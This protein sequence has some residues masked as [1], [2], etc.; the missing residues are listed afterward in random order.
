M[1]SAF[2]NMHLYCLGGDIPTVCKEV[3]YWLY[4]Y[5]D[6]WNTNYIIFRKKKKKTKQ[7]NQ[8]HT[9]PIFQYIFPYIFQFSLLHF[10][11][12]RRVLNSWTQFICFSVQI[13][14]EPFPLQAQFSIKYMCSN[15]LVDFVQWYVSCCVVSVKTRW[16]RQSNVTH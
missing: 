7:Q 6:L 15:F 13:F 8:T 1:F 2:G 3:C 5:P 16:L 12:P 11:L 14:K 4:T 9:F 10:T